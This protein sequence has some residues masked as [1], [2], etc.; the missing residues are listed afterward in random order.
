MYKYSVF[1]LIAVVFY[2][3]G[4]P[5][6]IYKSDLVY[7]AVVYNQKAF[8]TNNKA[9]LIISGDS[10][11]KLSG[12]DIQVG[13]VS[14]DVMPETKFIISDY[15]QK[16]APLVL[17]LS[18]GIYNISAIKLVSSD[19]RLSVYD[20]LVGSIKLNAGEMV[21]AG[22]IIVETLNVKGSRY[23]TS[24]SIGNMPDRIKPFIE[25][26]EN[27]LNKKAVIRLIEKT[28]VRSK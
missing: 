11:G 21:Y 9:L 7:S 24:F 17:M 3:C 26:Y 6:T 8:E 1:L 2:G 18:P 19:G 22:D 13:I 27:L 25:Q 4:M 14:G 12:M 15:S 16:R 5:H 23:L 20:G 28:D 10:Q